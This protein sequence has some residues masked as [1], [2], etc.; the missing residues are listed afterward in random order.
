[1]YDMWTDIKLFE[2]R[3]E[4]NLKVLKKVENIME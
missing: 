1:M 2:S 4:G 3:V